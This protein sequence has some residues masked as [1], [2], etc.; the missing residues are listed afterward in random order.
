MVTHRRYESYLNPERFC[1]AR[2]S[3][4]TARRNQSSPRPD[5]GYSSWVL[6][7][8]GRIIVAD[9]T[10]EDSPPGKASLKRYYLSPEELLRRVSWSLR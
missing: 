4:S 2:S 1:T 5:H 8:G 3:L 6:L 9:Y 7:P 10:N